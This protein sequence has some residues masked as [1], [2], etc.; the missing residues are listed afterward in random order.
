[1]G[2]LSRLGNGLKKWPA[3]FS[4]VWKELKKVKWPGRKEL[5]SYTV[6]VIVTVTLVTIFFAMIDS[7]IS[8]IIELIL[9]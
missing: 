9:G 3:F 7:G 8:R 1:M 2:F 6:V 4:D 5:I